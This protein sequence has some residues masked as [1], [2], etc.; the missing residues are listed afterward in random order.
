M[1]GGVLGLAK[2][3]SFGGGKNGG[4]LFKPPGVPGLKKILKRR[5]LVGGNGLK[6]VSDRRP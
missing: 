6:K 1:L 5:G 2:I 3:R 4:P